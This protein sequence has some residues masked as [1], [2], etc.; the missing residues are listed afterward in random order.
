MTLAV[1]A[2]LGLR[3]LQLSTIGAGFS[4][5]LTR[6][7]ERAVPSDRSAYGQVS[8]DL[9]CATTGDQLPR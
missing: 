7:L 4:I 6:Y 5:G 3:E 9:R 1:N 8:I 2:D